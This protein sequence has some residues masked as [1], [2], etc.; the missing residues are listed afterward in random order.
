MRFAG[1]L[2]F[3]GTAGI[4]TAAS[5]TFNFN[6]L[7]AGGSQSIAAGAT[8]TAI[9]TYM[10]SVLAAAGCT[11]CTVTVTGAVVDHTYNG[12]GHAVGNG[13]VSQT[14]GN[15][16]GATSN[17]SA[18]ASST[19][20]VTS[21]NFLSNT[22]DSLHNISS[23]ITLQFS[24]F[25]S[26]KLNGFDYEIFPG[27]SCTAMFGTFGY[28]NSNTCGGLFNSN[29]PNLELEAGTSTVSPVSSFGTNGFVY[30][31]APSKKSDGTAT[32]SPNGNSV[33][34]QNPETAPQYIGT[35]SGSVT[36]FTQ[37]D[38]VEWPAAIGVDNLSISWAPISSVPD[39]ASV[40]TLAT[41]LVVFVAGMWLRQRTAAGSSR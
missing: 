19:V 31:A 2:V 18:S 29:L 21:D 36:G 22:N 3:F 12:D 30:A 20:G 17:N 15:T 14:L 5:V 34:G 6:T 8:S 41:V 9:Q 4:A 13:G 35:W 27:S 38:F 10:N 7:S 37:L 25:T 40:L 11:G 1:F 16:D 24:G 33:N 28:P 39:P 26:L 32:S 23:Q